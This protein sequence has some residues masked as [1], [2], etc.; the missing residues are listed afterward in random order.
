[1][2]VP[3][4]RPQP[5]SF[6]PVRIQD[7]RGKFRPS[8]QEPL[9]GSSS[10]AAAAA[11]Q[12]SDHQGVMQ[13]ALDYDVERAIALKARTYLESD[14]Q[15]R[16]RYAQ[17]AALVLSMIFIGSIVVLLAM[18]CVKVNDVFD[19]VDGSDTSTKVSTLMDLAVEGAKNAHLATRNVLD[20]TSYARQT[21][22]VAAPQLEQV[23]NSTRDLVTDLRSWSF[24][25]SLQI[26]PGG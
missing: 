25:P 14:A 26:A 8:D 4:F 20:V 17:W 1:M 19:A 23:A 24:H 7:L 13:A 3:P 9:T 15:R 21:A 22:S 16:F 18:L 10:S 5:L 2:T 11:R 6:T 12:Q